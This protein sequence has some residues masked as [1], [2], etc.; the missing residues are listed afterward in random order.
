MNLIDATIS[1]NT[2]S[3]L[4]TP[5]VKIPYQLGSKN[6]KFFMSNALK[7]MLPSKQV[8]LLT[9]QVVKPVNNR[10]A[11]KFMKY[12]LDHKISL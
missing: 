1:Y 4:Q 2:F 10:L 9:E 11:H 12:I 5:N 7:R 6:S 3:L 8:I